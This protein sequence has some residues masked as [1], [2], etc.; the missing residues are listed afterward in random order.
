L[1]RKREK[2]KKGKKGARE[3]GTRNKSQKKD[4]QKK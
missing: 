1:Q 2:G 4:L 3:L